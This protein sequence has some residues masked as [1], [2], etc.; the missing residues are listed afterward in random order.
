M[1]ESWVA[2][3]LTSEILDLVL[4]ALFT[5]NKIQSQRISRYR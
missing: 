2:F 1:E 3:N 4:I 5:G